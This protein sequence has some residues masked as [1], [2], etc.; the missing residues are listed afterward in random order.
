MSRQWFFKLPVW[1]RAALVL[2]TGVVVIL[3]T[4]FLMLVVLLLLVYGLIYGVCW[5]IDTLR[6]QD[7]DPPTH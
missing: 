4:P 2:M 5:L 7:I 1:L 3:L 6:D